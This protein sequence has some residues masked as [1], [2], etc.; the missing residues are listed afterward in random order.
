MTNGDR[1]RSMSDE[2]LARFLCVVK[3]KLCF[4]CKY[5][6]VSECE[7]ISCEKAREQWL[8]QEISNAEM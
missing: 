7:G 6:H 5:E 1:L 8:K 2:E 3:E 4:A